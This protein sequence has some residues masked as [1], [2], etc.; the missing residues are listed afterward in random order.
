MVCVQ[1]PDLP[2]LRLDLCLRFGIPLSPRRHSLRGGVRRARLL[3]RL[4]Y[5][6][7]DACSESGDC[8]VRISVERFR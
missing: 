6:G 4:A 1:T 3:A 2:A 7:K 5:A 8:S